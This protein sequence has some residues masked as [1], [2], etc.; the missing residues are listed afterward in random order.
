MTASRLYSGIFCDSFFYLQA[1][2]ETTNNVTPEGMGAASAKL[3]SSY[4]SPY[5]W[6]T[7]FGPGRTDGASAVRIEKYT[8]NC[9]E[10]DGE[11][12][13]CFKYS[14]GNRPAG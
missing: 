10:V 11:M 14:G 6:S 4:E 12:R 1:I 7:T 9:V 3:G 13:G 2:L 8:L 5:T